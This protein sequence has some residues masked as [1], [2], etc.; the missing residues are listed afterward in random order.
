MMHENRRISTVI[1]LT[2]SHQRRRVRPYAWT[3]FFE[4]LSSNFKFQQNPTR[5]MR[6]LHEDVSKLMIISRSILLRKINVLNK[7]CRKNQNTHCVFSNFFFLAEN[8]A[9]YEMSKSLVE[10]ERLLE[11]VWRR[12]SWWISK[13]T[14]AQAHGRSPTPTRNGFVHASQRHLIRTL[15]V[16]LQ[17]TPV[18]HT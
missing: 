6:T 7:S 1:F 13:A 3:A 14:R 17:G 15:R 11:T 10:P 16:L 4:N 12:V 8:R 5:T 18:P 2:R 9:V